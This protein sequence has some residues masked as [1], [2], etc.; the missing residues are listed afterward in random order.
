MLEGI[1][2]WE[3]MLSDS[4]AVSIKI[5]YVCWWTHCPFKNLMGRTSVALSADK[6]L[7]LKILLV[8]S[9]QRN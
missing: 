4:Y 2:L 5:M 7:Y 8:T 3:S 9:W 1:R 6:N